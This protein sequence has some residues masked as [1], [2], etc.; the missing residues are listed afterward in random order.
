MLDNAIT[1]LTERAEQ[2]VRPNPDYQVTVEK[3][4]IMAR[5]A[6]LATTNVSCGSKTA[7]LL[8]NCMSG[9][10]SELEDDVRQLAKEKDS[11]RVSFLL[12]E[13]SAID[14]IHLT[15]LR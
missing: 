9:T 15:H 3:G 1:P 8:V 11:K 7:S 12:S 4:T 14:E 13:R 10:S 2:G 6:R 5:P